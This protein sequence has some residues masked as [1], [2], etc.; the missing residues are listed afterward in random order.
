VSSYPFTE[1]V[2]PEDKQKFI[3]IPTKKYKNPIRTSRNITSSI[4]DIGLEVSTGPVVD[5]RVKEFT[6][7]EPRSNTVPLLYPGH[8]KKMQ[9]IWPNFELNKPN[10]I[11]KHEATKK[12]LFPTGFYVVVKRFSSKEQVKRIV[13]NVATPKA[14]NSDFI[15]FENH[16]NVFHNN[17]EGIREELAYGLV[18]YLNSSFVDNYF[19]EFNGHTQVNAA[20]LKSLMYPTTEILLELGKSAKSRLPL[21]QEST[22]RIIEAIL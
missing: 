21:D 14:F 10:F 11:L 13:A 20:D 22:D 16:L 17:K 8:F 7:N 18:I 1:I 3:F 15:G 6:T 9:V 5:F 4:K 2:K 19:R 12:W